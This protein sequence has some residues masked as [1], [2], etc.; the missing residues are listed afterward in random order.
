L[1]SNQT[2]FALFTKD[3]LNEI[4]VSRSIKIFK[5]LY[6]FELKRKSKYQTINFKICIQRKQRNH[7][8]I[9]KTLIN[10][11]IVYLRDRIHRRD[12][13]CQKD[14]LITKSDDSINKR[15][16]IFSSDNDIREQSR[17]LLRWKDHLIELADCIKT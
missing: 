16:Q 2:Y 3:I 1:T 7:Q 10:R 4:D 9:F 12:V 11:D 13:N 14:Y 6:K 15:R 5:K 8:L 17:S